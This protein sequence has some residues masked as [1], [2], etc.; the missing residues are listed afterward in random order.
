MASPPKI[1]TVRETKMLSA[2]TRQIDFEMR[3]QD[4]GFVGGQYVIMDSRRMLPTG[5]AAKRAY[6]IITPDTEQRN[7]SLVVKRVGEGLCSNYLHEVQPGDE[8]RFS[9]PWGKLKVVDEAPQGEILVAATDS[10]ISAAL[11]LLRGQVMVP[12][13]P[14]TRVLWMRTEG[15]VMSEE[16]LSSWMPSGC[17]GVE[18]RT[19]PPVHHPERLSVAFQHLDKARDAHQPRHVFMAGDGAVLLPYA[20]QLNEAGIETPPERVHCFFNM[21]KKSSS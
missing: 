10:G 11:G 20:E 13:L 17:A 15:E 19:I 2:D 8:L 7:L 5:K 3:D 12:A 4:L 16:Q 1:A 6:S 18:I 21:P 9:G 14:R